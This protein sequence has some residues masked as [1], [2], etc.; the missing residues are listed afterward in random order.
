V[1]ELL[2]DGD[3]PIADGDSAHD[4]PGHKG[5][6]VV[7]KVAGAGAMAAALGVV[8]GDIGTRFSGANP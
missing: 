2:A 1:T 4:E 6:G 5:R 3:G 7:G 8:S